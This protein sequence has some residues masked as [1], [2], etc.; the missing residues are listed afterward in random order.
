MTQMEQTI[1]R[2]LLTHQVGYQIFCPRC[3]TVLDVRSAVSLDVYDGE[4]LAATKAFCAK[5]W[6]KQGAGI[7]ER[8]EAKGL[9]V[10][11]T[12]GRTLFTE[13]RV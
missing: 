9:T 1:T 7:T 6:A 13:K 4:K 10:K 11:I 8:L 5:C 3:Q 12:D 2:N